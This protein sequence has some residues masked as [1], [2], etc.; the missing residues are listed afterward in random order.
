MYTKFRKVWLRHSKYDAGD[1]QT[2]RQQDDFISLLS[3]F[4]CKENRLKCTTST[5]NNNYNNFSAVERYQKLT[6]SSGLLKT[7]YQDPDQYMI[8]HGYV[9]VKCVS[10]RH[11][12]PMIYTALHT[13]KAAPSGT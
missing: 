11:V 5:L 9:L 3:V 13:S 7:H 12:T 10:F 8:T 4:Q 2:Q 6:F 1:A